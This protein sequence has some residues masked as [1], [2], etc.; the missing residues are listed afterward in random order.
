MTFSHVATFLKANSVLFFLCLCA[1][2]NLLCSKF[3]YIFPDS[4][5]RPNLQLEQIDMIGRKADR[6]GIELQ[7]GCEG[8]DEA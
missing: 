7:E 3:I 5:L 8:Q 2:S 6:K 4:Y 1:H